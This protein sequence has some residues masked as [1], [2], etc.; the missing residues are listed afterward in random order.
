[1]HAPRQQSPPRLRAAGVTLG[2]TLAA[3]VTAIPAAATRVDAKPPE[4][5]SHPLTAKGAAR[6][7]Q[8]SIAVDDGRTSTAAG[9]KLTYTI[10]IRNLGTTGVT[11]LGVTQSVPDGQKFLSADPAATAKAG[12]VSWRRDLKVAGTATVHTTMSVSATPKELLRLATVA[13]ASMT[14]SKP[15]LVCAS[16]SDQLPAGAS[17][18]AAAAKAASS[19]TDQPWWYLASGIGGIGLIVAAL[20]ALMTRRRRTPQTG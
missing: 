13:C 2:I 14:A 10:T 7:P 12:R 6:G 19:S 20:A 11:G 9:D 5:H 8:L 17:A 18:Q 15:P 16:D 3:V 1:M 4:T